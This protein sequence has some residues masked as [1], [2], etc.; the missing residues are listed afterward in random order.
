MRLLGV[1][2]H[3]HHGKSRL[4]ETVESVIEAT[5]LGSATRS[6]IL[7]VEIEHKFAAGKVACAEHSAIGSSAKNFGNF[8]SNFHINRCYL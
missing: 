7:G 5:S 3:A 4:G 1:F 2:A 8:V 6:V